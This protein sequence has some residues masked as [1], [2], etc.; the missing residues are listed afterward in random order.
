MLADVILYLHASFVLF[1]VG[2]LV[3]VWIGAALSSAWCT[4]P[5]FRG[6]HAAAIAIVF[7][8]SW[9]GLAC[10]L[11]MWEDALRGAHP[12]AGFVARWVRA[13]LFW[14]LPSWVFTGLYTGFA[15][16]VAWTWMRV[17]P[18]RKRR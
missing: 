16:L 14:D 7:A 8:E 11:T 10:P 18:R 2:G 1:V 9:L 15:L 17:P 12:T 6:M 3:A 13:W 4:N 5:W